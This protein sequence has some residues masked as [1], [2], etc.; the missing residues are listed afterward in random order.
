[1]VSPID[2]EAA[3][4]PFGDHLRDQL[5][6][7]TGIILRISFVHLLLY[8]ILIIKLSNFNYGQVI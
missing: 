7:S 6:S 2:A 5:S 4:T 3:T 8:I 1:M